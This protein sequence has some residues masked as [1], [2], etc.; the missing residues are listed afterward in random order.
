MSREIF[1]FLKIGNYSVE[2]LVKSRQQQGRQSFG[3]RIAH[4]WLPELTTYL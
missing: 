1:E 4:L 3:E 2:F